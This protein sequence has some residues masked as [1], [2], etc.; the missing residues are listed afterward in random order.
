MWRNIKTVN[1]SA[2]NLINFVFHITK[3]VDMEKI[4][5][6]TYIDKQ[7]TY[8]KLAKHFNVSESTI[9]YW[10]KKFGLKTK[11]NRYNNYGKQRPCFC[12]ICGELDKNNFYKRGGNKLFCSNCHKEVHYGMDL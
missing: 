8:K 11:N 9:R 7:Y 12:K 2:I 10:M 3:L 4:E 1:V 6:Q 5:L